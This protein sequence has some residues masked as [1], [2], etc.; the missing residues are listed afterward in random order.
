MFGGCLT[1]DCGQFISIDTNQ[2][3]KI[4][5]QF[6]NLWQIY[7]CAHIW[8]NKTYY[9]DLIC[10]RTSLLKESQLN[11]KAVTAENTTS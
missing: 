11:V 7:L 10:F 1:R 9:N 6:N 8:E 3:N 5:R 4:S 2:N